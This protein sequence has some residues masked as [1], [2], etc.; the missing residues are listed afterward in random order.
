M[1]RCDAKQKTFAR[2][3]YF[4]LKICEY[5]KKKEKKPLSRMFHFRLGRKWKELRVHFDEERRWIFFLGRQNDEQSLTFV[6]PISSDEHLS[7]NDLFTMK[8]KF[9]S[10]LPRKIDED[11]SRYYVMYLNSTFD[12]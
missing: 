8:D 3:V 6:L 12:S 4:D 7:T 9:L 5:F 10:I 2:R 1:D 11:V